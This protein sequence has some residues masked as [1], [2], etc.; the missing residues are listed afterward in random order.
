MVG[1]FEGQHQHGLLVAPRDAGQRLARL[2]QAAVGGIEARLGDV[3]HRVGAGI[4][5]AEA[6]AGGGAEGRLLAQA[7]PGLGDDAQDAFGADEHAVGAGAG[8]GAGQAARFQRAGG[9]HDARA[10]HEIVDVG[11]ERGVV[12]ARA[13][14]DPAAQGRAAIGLHVV[15]HGERRVAQRVLDRRARRC[16]PGCARPGSPHRPPAPCPCG[17]SRSSRPC[18]T[19]PR[20]RCPS[21]PTS[22]RHRG[23]PWRRSGRTSRAPCTMSSSVSGKA[24]ASGGLGTERMNMRS[25]SKP[26]LP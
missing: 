13:R 11:V 20:A 8:A 25:V 9:R 16:R 12:A 6:H 22:R 15:A 21:P 3:A 1:R 26:A 5:V 19:R 10:F 24:T 18:R 4:E 7:H 2:E 17:A 23:S 14:G